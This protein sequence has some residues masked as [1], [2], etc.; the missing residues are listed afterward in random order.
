MKAHFV[1][2]VAS[3]ILV[4]GCGQAAGN[5]Q[6]LP[7]VVLETSGGAQPQ[8]TGAPG[9]LSASSVVASGEVVPAQQAQLAFAVAGQIDQVMVGVGDEVEAGQVL[10]RLSGGEALQ[11]AVSEAD[12]NVLKAQQ[13][14]DD[15]TSDP[16]W[17]MALAQAQSDLA[18]A[19]DELR[20]ADYDRTVNQKGY[21]ASTLTIQSAEAKLVLAKEALDDAKSAYD[22]YADKPSDDPRRAAALAKYSNAQTAYNSALRT[23]NWYKGHP[24]ELQQSQLD[25]AVALAQAK[26]DEAQQR[27]D[28]LQAGP[29]PDQVALLSGQLASAKDQAAAARGQLGELELR[30]PFAGTVGKVVAQEGEWVSPGQ[31]AMVIADLRHLRVQTTDLSERDVPSVRLGQSASISIDALNATAEATVREISPLAD[32]LGGDVVYQTTLDLVSV[33]DGLRPGMT[34]DVQFLGGG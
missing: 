14:L 29:D 32:T 9:D 24:T 18:A 30:A 13:A 22:H 34:V 26:V 25:A 2:L 20:I 3:A 10:A 5:S 33:P 17:K 4:A 15:Q 6:A 21:R 16:S 31:A 12:L 27:V 8:A 1:W 23:V 28:K 19:K 11:A 7:T